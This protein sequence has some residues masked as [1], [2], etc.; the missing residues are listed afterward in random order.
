MK[1][2]ECNNCAYLIFAE[3][4]AAPPNSCP[5]CRGPMYHTDKIVKNEGAASYTCGEC[6][7]AFQTPAG[8][9]M[10][11]KCAQCNFTFP[12]T[13]RRKVEHKL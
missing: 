1:A 12:S 7:Y 4:T 13:P 5:M 6:G 10:P 9:L 8:A 11:Y 3:E 2:Y